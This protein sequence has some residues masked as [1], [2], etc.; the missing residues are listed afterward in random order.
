[1]FVVTLLATATRGTAV[2]PSIGIVVTSSVVPRFCSHFD[3]IARFIALFYA[4]MLG[5]ETLPA[6][7]R[8]FVNVSMPSAQVQAGLG[9]IEIVR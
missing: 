4:A 2:C 6:L 5:V 8:T 9:D 3:I 1:M 7:Y